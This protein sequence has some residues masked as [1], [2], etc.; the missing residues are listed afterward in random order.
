MPPT[1]THK[2]NPER[3]SARRYDL[4]LPIA[5]HTA[6]PRQAGPL[7]GRTR[8]ISTRGVY[9]TIEWGFIPGSEIEFTLTLP[10]KLA[11]GKEAFVRCEGKVVRTEKRRENETE[12]IGVAAVI[13]SYDLVRGEPRIS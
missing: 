13:V 9:F 7:I 2:G 1:Q 11:H 12:R 6:Q 5:V 10:G 3:R 8:D 4:A